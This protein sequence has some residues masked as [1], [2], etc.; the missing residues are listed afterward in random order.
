GP[1]ALADVA[2]LRD[3]LTDHRGE[4]ARAVAQRELEELCAVALRAHLGAADE[5]D[6][7]CRK[8]LRQRQGRGKNKTICE[9]GEK[10][11]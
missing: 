1:A 11:T 3:V 7:A 4:L 9:K 10:K 2:Q 5:E 6:L 8:G